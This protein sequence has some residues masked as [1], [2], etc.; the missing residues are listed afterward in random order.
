MFIQRPGGAGDRH[1][2]AEIASHRIERNPYNLRHLTGDLP[3]GWRRAAS[4]R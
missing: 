3:T 2:G 1:G 4:P